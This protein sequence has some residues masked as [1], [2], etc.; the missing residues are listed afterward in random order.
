MQWEIKEHPG[1]FKDLDKLGKQELEIFFRKKNKIKEN[2]L[3]LKHLSGG[4]HCYRE[5]ITSNI[6]LIYFLQGQTIWL[7]TI[8][9]HDDAYKMYIRRLYAL[10]DK[11]A[12]GKII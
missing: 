5:P 6:R 3:R 2:P 8:G 10:R 7:L 4:E 11:M 1:F 9:R 12:R